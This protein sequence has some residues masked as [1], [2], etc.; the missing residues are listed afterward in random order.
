MFKSGHCKVCC[1]CLVNINL[2]G[3]VLLL[4][5]VWVTLPSKIQCSTVIKWLP[6]YIQMYIC[7]CTNPISQSE[8]PHHRR[9]S[10]IRYKFKFSTNRCLCK[11]GICIRVPYSTN[12]TFLYIYSIFQYFPFCGVKIICIMLSFRSFN[13]IWSPWYSLSNKNSTSLVNILFL[14]KFI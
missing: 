10:H 13:N 14:R 8:T 7:I 1:T 5:H 6:S 2:S 12:A 4:F 9:T 11:I 3:K